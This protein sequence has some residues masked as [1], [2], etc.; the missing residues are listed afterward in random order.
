LTIDRGIRLTDAGRVAAGLPMAA[1][2]ASALEAR[3]R[4]A[5]KEDVES[6]DR[7]VTSI[8]GSSLG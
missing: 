3:V 1:A 2:Q 7:L 4:G 6:P 5:R 8:Y